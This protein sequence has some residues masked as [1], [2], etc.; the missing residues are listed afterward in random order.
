MLREDLQRREVGLVSFEHG[1]I[2]ALFCRDGDLPPP[3]VQAVSCILDTTHSSMQR[4]D[5][6][7]P[8][9]D[10]R[11]YQ[12]LHMIQ[13]VISVSLSSCMQVFTTDC[14]FGRVKGITSFTAQIASYLKQQLLT[15]FLGPGNMQ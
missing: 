14:C 8:V 11:V 15:C 5:E 6:M 7:S 9:L 3:F 4:R 12:A 10:S 2:E 13:I 1:F